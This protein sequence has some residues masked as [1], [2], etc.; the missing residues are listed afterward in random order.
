MQAVRRRLKQNES[1]RIPERSLN[2]ELHAS[3]HD[4]A[5]ATF[6]RAGSHSCQPDSFVT[7]RRASRGLITDDKT[8]DQMGRMPNTGTSPEQAVARYLDRN[9]IG[10]AREKKDILGNPNL[11]D[12]NKRWARFVSGCFWNHPPGCSS[13]T[14]PKRNTRVWFDKFDANR[15]RDRRAVHALQ[16]M[17]FMVHVLWECEMGSLPRH[18]AMRTLPHTAAGGRR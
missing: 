9:H 16:E 17:G 10:Y 7:R 2:V 3:T 15:R 5:E 4:E 12:R 18:P 6:E 1:K 8:S 11:A 14:I 13:A